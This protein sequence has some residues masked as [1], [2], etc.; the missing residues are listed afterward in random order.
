M[1]V[2]GGA[3]VAVLPAVRVYVLVRPRKLER[4]TTPLLHAAL[5]TPLVDADPHRW[6]LFWIMV[7]VE[8]LSELLWGAARRC[9]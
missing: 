3:A 7:A 2:S 4:A 8:L 6:F 9:T 5:D 1:R